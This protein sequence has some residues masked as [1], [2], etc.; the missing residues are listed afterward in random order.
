MFPMKSNGPGEG[1]GVGGLPHRLPPRHASPA[2][3]Q[4]VP[5]VSP[6]LQTQSGPSQLRL[7]GQQW[8]AGGGQRW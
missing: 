3:Q 1:G 4:F 8:T 7:G 2:R 6:D 5:Q